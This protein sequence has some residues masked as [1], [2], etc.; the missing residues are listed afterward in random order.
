[1]PPP[2]HPRIIAHYP[3]RDI[4]RESHPMIEA[5]GT[6]PA[7][8]AGHGLEA[9][10]N[11]RSIAV[12]GASPRNAYALR[13]ISNLRAVEYAGPIYPVNPH[14]RSVADLH[15]YP[16][17]SAIQ[18]H[19]DA[20]VVAVGAD[21]VPAVL[22]DVAAVG[23]S[24]AVVYAS[25]IGEGTTPI[26]PDL[27]LT[28]KRIAES[29]ATR[30]L[31]PNCLGVV[32]FADGCAMWGIT[33]PMAHMAREDGVALIAQS[34][35]MALTA[36]SAERGVRFTRIVTC[37]NQLDLT[38]A[39]LIEQMLLAPGTRGIAAIVET[40]PDVPRFRRVLDH[41]AELELPVVVLR[42]GR[43]DAG[44]LAALAHTGSLSA[45]ERFYRALFRQYGAVQ[46]DDLDE[47]LATCALLTGPRRMSGS[48]V[49]GFASSG[50][51][52][53]ILS[54]LAADHGLEFPPLPQRVVRGLRDRL[55]ENAAPR[56]PLDLTASAWGDRDIYR[57]A[58][59]AL[60][61]IEGIDAVVHVGDVP[62]RAE[63]G[64]ESGWQE[65][66]SGLVD[67][68]AVVP[69]PVVSLST[70]GDIR[71]E[72]VAGLR[73]GGIVPLVGLGPGVA[74]LGHAARYPAAAR[75]ARR[76]VNES[77]EID[78]RRRGRATALLAGSDG[79]VDE[80]LAKAVIRLYGISS[81]AG[82]VVRSEAQAV[83]ASERLGFPVVMKLHRSRV[84]HK[85]DVGG[86][87][88]EIRDAAGAR[89]GFGRLRE[90]ARVTGAADPGGVL[91]ERRVDGGPELIVGG[92]ND[93]QFGPTVM[94]GLG[95]VLCEL[96]P[97]VTHR[98][99]PVDLEDALTMLGELRAVESLDGYRGR[100]RVDRTSVAAAIVGVAQLLGEL[101]EVSEL[102]LNPVVSD[103]NGRGCLA[104]DA[105]IVLD[106]SNGVARSER[107]A[108]RAGDA[109]AR[110]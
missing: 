99:A 42:V 19:V 107:H 84:A 60:G 102:D 48:S 72:V 77:V 94:V 87:L 8:D 44:R 76:H 51:E 40:I 82:V 62:S 108:S 90:V 7:N 29:S 9:L 43:S 89:A 67:G 64:D 75:A 81:P 27:A 39:E 55:P 18:D 33:M 73:A 103:A 26:R 11:P 32:S 86:V 10:I 1:M 13:T 20:V 41:A 88:V 70:I 49:A 25:G 68:A 61:Q 83:E 22:E 5:Q 95:G 105:L 2:A 97:D 110:A 17:L 56:N 106:R 53:A 100:P 59:E 109:E 98:L 30:V 54:D 16:S 24:I 35:N 31:G 92:R 85:S 3:A 12:V 69:Q 37:G 47:L 71:S 52:C 36:M 23:S 58:V 104:L 78:P 28:V 80:A 14:H 74:A 4:A 50:G 15:C 93:P 46:V 6:R 66:I 38:A 65:I 101:P 21:T 34:G 57:R 45:P 96:V 63:E 91:V 79:A